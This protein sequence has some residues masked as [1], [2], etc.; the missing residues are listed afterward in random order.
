M[1]DQ[2][3]MIETVLALAT[4]TDRWRLEPVPGPPVNVGTGISLRPYGLRMRVTARKPTPNTSSVPAAE[5][6]PNDR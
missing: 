3:A 4:I 5:P 6:D 1:G 2:F